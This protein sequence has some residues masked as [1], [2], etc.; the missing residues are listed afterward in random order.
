[1]TNWEFFDNQ[2]PESTVRLVDDLRAGKD[3]KPT[4]GPDRVCTFKQVSR[5]LAGF[6]DG[7]ADQGPG[8]GPASLLGLRIAREH[9]WEAP[10]GEDGPNS[11]AA[12]TDGK[13]G[14]K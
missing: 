8:A 3:V 5:V 4:R 14:P 12:A 1:M 11:S 13:D 2:T 10:H 9:G 7:L 6:S